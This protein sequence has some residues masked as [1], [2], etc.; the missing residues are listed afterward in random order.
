MC[1]WFEFNLLLFEVE[2]YVYKSQNK[3]KLK[4]K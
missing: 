2:K 1:G 4:K 3:M